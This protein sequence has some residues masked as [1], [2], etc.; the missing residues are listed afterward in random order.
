M[1]YS[2]RAVDAWASAPHHSNPHGAL[3]HDLSFVVPPVVIRGMGGSKGLVELERHL[4]QRALNGSKIQSL[5][6][7]GN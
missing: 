6:S 7:K 5:Q 4:P 3:Q 1:T 2:S